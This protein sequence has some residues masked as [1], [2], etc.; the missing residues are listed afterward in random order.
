MNY[1]YR[2]S[3]LFFPIRLMLVQAKYVPIIVTVVILINLLF[4]DQQKTSMLFT[5]NFF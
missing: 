2:L 4:K 1:D 3:D 5:L